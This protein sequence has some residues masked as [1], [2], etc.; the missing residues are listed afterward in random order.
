M[1]RSCGCAEPGCSSE[2]CTL[3]IINLCPSKGIPLERGWTKTCFPP[4]LVT[5]APLTGGTG[6]GFLAAALSCSSPLV[7]GAGWAGLSPQAAGAVSLRTSSRA[8]GEGSHHLCAFTFCAS[9]PAPNILP[10]PAPEMGAL[11]NT[12]SLTQNSCHKNTWAGRIWPTLSSRPCTESLG[13]LSLWGHQYWAWNEPPDT[14]NPLGCSGPPI[15]HP[16]WWHWTPRWL[17]GRSPAGAAGDPPVPAVT[18]ARGGGWAGREQ[19]DPCGHCWKVWGWNP[20]SS[21]PWDRGP[22]LLSLGHQELALG[23]LC[24]PSGTSRTRGSPSLSVPGPLTLT[25]IL[26]RMGGTGQL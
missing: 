4:V 22:V 16:Q 15:V 13:F 23:W 21:A 2:F 20:E 18:G 1:E 19:Q 14:E 17:L 25:G 12:G 24:H 3:I 9:H 7:D 10:V 5:L 6:E 26:Q 11:D 8:P